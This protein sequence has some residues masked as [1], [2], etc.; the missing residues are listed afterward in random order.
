MVSNSGRYY[1]R[2]GGGHDFRRGNDYIYASN[3]QHAVNSKPTTSLGEMKSK[4][5]S[6]DIE[7]SCSKS[8]NPTQAIISSEQ[9]KNGAI[10]ATLQAARFS[11]SVTP[12]RLRPSNVKESTITPSEESK[13]S[14][15]QNKRKQDNILAHLQAERFTRAIASKAMEINGSN[16]HLEQ[17]TDKSAYEGTMSDVSSHERYNS[18]PNTTLQ[19]KISGGSPTTITE[20]NNPNEIR[21]NNS[22]KYMRSWNPHIASK[23]AERFSR[24]INESPIHKSESKD[25][26]TSR[27]DIYK[28]EILRRKNRLAALQAKRFQN[29]LDNDRSSSEKD[30]GE[31]EV[32]TQAQNGN[33]RVISDSPRSHFFPR[34][35]DL[36]SNNNH[37][38]DEKRNS[39]DKEKTLSHQTQVTVNLSDSQSAVEEKELDDNWKRAEDEEC[40]S[41][42]SLDNEEDAISADAVSI[43]ASNEVNI[44]VNKL[45]ETVS[46]FFDN[47]RGKIRAGEGNDSNIEWQDQLFEIFRKDESNKVGETSQL[48]QIGVEKNKEEDSEE[49]T[50]SP[51]PIELKK[52]SSSQK[53]R[54][55][56]VINAARNIVNG[57]TRTMDVKQVQRSFEKTKKVDLAKSIIKK[58]SSETVSHDPMMSCLSGDD[59]VSVISKSPSRKITN[60]ISNKFPSEKVVV[61]DNKSRNRKMLS[62]PIS[63]YQMNIDKN[64]SNQVPKDEQS[65]SS[66]ANEHIRFNSF[67]KRKASVSSSASSGG[68]RISSKYNNADRLS[69]DSSNSS[70]ASSGSTTFRSESTISR[71][72][73]FSEDGSHVKNIDEHTRK[74]DTQMTKSEDSILDTTDGFEV[75][76][77][78]LSSDPPLSKDKKRKEKS[79]GKNKNVMKSYTNSMVD[80]Y[81]SRSRL[82]E[83][84]TVS[85]S[86]SRT[87]SVST[88]DDKVSNYNQSSIS[89]ESSATDVLSTFSTKERELS[90]SASMGSNSSGSCSSESKQDDTL[91]SRQWYNYMSKRKSAKHRASIPKQKESDLGDLI[92]RKYTRLFFLNKDSSTSSMDDMEIKSKKHRES[93]SFGLQNSNLERDIGKLT[94]DR[95]SK[96][97]F[98]LF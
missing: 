45:Q 61:H 87:Y 50:L 3:F 48:D 27:A 92:D 84:Q 37:N 65:T 32:I 7:K 96:R 2:A 40:T 31:T 35:E 67:I 52:D 63:R 10:I 56:N 8:I 86:A 82:S 58:R 34:G 77:S 13:K 76:L 12:T 60:G 21:K 44:S 22:I 74:T 57:R 71:L 80:S 20:D 5:S 85:Q 1:R 70:S 43:D 18:T 73:D 41:N 26:I 28:R 69:F 93:I 29:A 16:K 83:S 59:D 36:S 46:N 98:R 72:H 39:F 47:F 68:S 95:F 54:E 14:P 88:M 11:R 94:D 55:S 25:K 38:H 17:E 49:R 79:M 4:S 42:L 78:G 33:T 90:G 19:S 51:K 9:R 66:S 91:M 6:K 15:N 75:S 89:G 30:C 64:G 53:R 23:Q 24:A 97:F 62:S 81:R